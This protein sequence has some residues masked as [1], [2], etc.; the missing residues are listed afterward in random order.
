MTDLETPVF[1]N[2]GLGNWSRM[3]NSGGYGM[4]AVRDDQTKS[5]IKAWSLWE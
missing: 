4:D 1:I 3:T 5:R 2:K